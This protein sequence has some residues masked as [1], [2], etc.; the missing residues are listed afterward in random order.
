MNDYQKERAERIQ[1]AYETSLA[2]AAAIAAELTEQTGHQWT[3]HC[4]PDREADTPHFSL[5]RER[6]RLSLFVGTEW[7]KKTQWQIAPSKIKTAAGERKLYDHR[8]H[9]PA[10]W[11]VLSSREKTPAQI[12]K[13]ILR[14]VMPQAEAAAARAIESANA[15]LQRKAWIDATKAKLIEANPD[16]EPEQYKKDTAHFMEELHSEHTTTTIF[17]GGRSISITMRDLDTDTAAQIMRT[18]RHAKKAAKSHA[19]Q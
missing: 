8:T 5:L 4:D 10:A 3:G 18:L 6:D 16:L 11:S 7:R 1:E 13:D 14:R 12:A 15:E 19:A 9:N 2:A 17:A